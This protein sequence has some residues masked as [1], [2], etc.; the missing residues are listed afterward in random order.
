M[1]PNQLKESTVKELL[2]AYKNKA[3]CIHSKEK[4]K[5]IYNELEKRLGPVKLYDL[6]LATWHMQNGE[7]DAEFNEECDKLMKEYN[8]E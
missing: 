8:S 3:R 1:T 6:R 5:S 7:S 2:I 4:S